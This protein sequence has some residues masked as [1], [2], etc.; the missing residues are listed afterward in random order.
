MGG[1]SDNINRKTCKGWVIVSNETN[2]VYFGFLDKE[3]SISTPISN[4]IEVF[5]DEDSYRER[6]KEITGEYPPI[7]DE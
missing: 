2:V 6:Y 4:T 7:E 3:R 5:Q 1:Q